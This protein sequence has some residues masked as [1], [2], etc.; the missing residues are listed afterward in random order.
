MIQAHSMNFGIQLA[1]S[2]IHSHFLHLPVLI[3]VVKG[4]QEHRTQSPLA[5]TGEG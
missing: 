2:Q 3:G 4:Y 5:P 1:W